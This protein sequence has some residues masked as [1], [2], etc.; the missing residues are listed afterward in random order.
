[1]LHLCNICDSCEIHEDLI[2]P[3][4]NTGFGFHIFIAG[5]IINIGEFFRM[6]KSIIRIKIIIWKFDIFIVKLYIFRKNIIDCGSA[7]AYKFFTC[8]EFFD[9][10]YNL[11]DFRILYNLLAFSFFNQIN[12]ISQN[13]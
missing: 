9:D 12:R 3:M 11:L 8:D 1:M 4:M 10:G 7:I 13:F 5:L 6:V 2:C